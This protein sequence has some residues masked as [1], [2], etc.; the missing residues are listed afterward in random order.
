MVASASHSATTRPK[1]EGMADSGAN[2]N[3]L[4]SS[5]AAALVNIRKT[6]GGLLLTFPNG[7]TARA[8]AK[9]TLKVL[10]SLPEAA[11]TAYLFRNLTCGSLLAMGPLARNNN[12]VTYTSTAVIVADAA[13]T[14]I[15]RGKYCHER[16][17]YFIDLM[18]PAPPAPTPPRPM[19]VGDCSGHAAQAS[20][21]LAIT[22]TGKRE[23]VRYWHRVMGS[24]VLSTFLAAIRAGFLLC[25]PGLTAELVQ[26]HDPTWLG[27][28]LGH[29]KRTRQGQRSTKVKPNTAQA[30]AFGD[31][32][33]TD[34]LEGESANEWHLPDFSFRRELHH[35]PRY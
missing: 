32:D 2:V 17:L 10:A 6:P 19:Q 15:L 1:H 29:L 9:G 11:K 18:P 3:A 28:S 25:I 12:T 14:E 7:T 26:K 16:Q 23:F 5:D 13:G 34:K 30:I 8:Y 21:N 33:A 35:G 4:D 20:A 31:E 27:V 22:H 24:P